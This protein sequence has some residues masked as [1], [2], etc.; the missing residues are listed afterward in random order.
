MLRYI[1]AVLRLH[2]HHVYNADCFQFD[3]NLPQLTQQSLAFIVVQSIYGQPSN[4]NLYKWNGRVRL[5]SLLLLL[6]SAR[7]SPPLLLRGHCCRGVAKVSPQ[8]CQSTNICYTCCA[9]ACTKCSSCCNGCRIVYAIS[10]WIFATS[11]SCYLWGASL[12]VNF[13]LGGVV[14]CGVLK[15]N[16]NCPFH[17]CVLYASHEYF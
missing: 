10:K 14:G 13:T 16:Y 17:Y 15:K 7:L 5:I 8:P 1:G 2:N 6:L 9:G 4:S 11:L 12:I 3:C